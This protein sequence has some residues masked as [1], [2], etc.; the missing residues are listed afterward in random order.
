VH[1]ED[2]DDGRNIHAG[3]EVGSR[4]LLLPLHHRRVVQESERKIQAEKRRD[5]K[6]KEADMRVEE[7]ER[8]R[9]RDCD[10]NIR[11]YD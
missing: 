5:M 9:E 8:E 2:E 7:R 3:H 6:R 4:L 1:D 10:C 11:I